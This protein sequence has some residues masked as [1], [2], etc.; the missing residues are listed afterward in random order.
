M[1]WFVLKAKGSS[2][3]GFRSVYRPERGV[4]STVCLENAKRF[5]SLISAENARN[6]L[7]VPRLWTVV[8]LDVELVTAREE[9][10]ARR[11]AMGL[12]ESPTLFGEEV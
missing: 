1:G 2:D 10:K 4:G 3:S 7:A 9:A 11:L 5:G 8:A 12:S 6:K